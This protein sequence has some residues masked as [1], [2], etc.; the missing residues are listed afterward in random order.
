M[1]RRRDT[2][3]NVPEIGMPDTEGPP[4]G[5]ANLQNFCENSERDSDYGSVS[6]M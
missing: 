4:A 5:E 6:A 1:E 2:A 3:W